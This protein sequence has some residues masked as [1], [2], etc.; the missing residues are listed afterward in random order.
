MEHPFLSKRSTQTRIIQRFDQDGDGQLNR[1]ERQAA[2]TAW[3]NYRQN[4]GNPLR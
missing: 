4:Q 2:N 1:E 3:Q